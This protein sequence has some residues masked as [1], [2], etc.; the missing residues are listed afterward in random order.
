VRLVL[1]VLQWAA[2]TLP[3]PVQAAFWL[4]FVRP[5]A[6]LVLSSPLMGGIDPWAA[7]KWAFPELTRRRVD[8]LVWQALGQALLLIPET[9]AAP[10]GVD[11]VEVEALDALVP[12]HAEGQGVLVAS[13]H[14]GNF[15]L[16]AVGTARALAP[17]GLTLTLPI[18]LRKGD[19]ASEFVGEM[20]AAGGVEVVPITGSGPVER[21]RAARGAL[22]ALRRGGI[23]AMA[24]DQ[25]SGSGVPALFFGRRVLAPA[26]IPALHAATLAPV[27]FAWGERRPGGHVVRAELL[28]FTGSV[29]KDAQTLVSAVE[30]RVRERPE[31]WLWFGEWITRLARKG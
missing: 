7:V 1:R 28:S 4:W 8:A 11:R 31:Q 23:V 24:A 3:W 9:L 12:L 22:R 15:L 19:P 6:W 5:I 14:Q 21:G 30:R 27:L 2:K 13:L 16:M 25:E 10:R 20:L 29:E 18:E 17:H 26:G